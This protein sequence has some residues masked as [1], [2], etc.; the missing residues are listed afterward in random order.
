LKTTVADQTL[1]S[2]NV[3][4]GDLFEVKSKDPS[5]FRI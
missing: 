2:V 3:G 4:L 1:I 5:E